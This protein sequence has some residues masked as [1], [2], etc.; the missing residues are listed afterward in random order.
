M[1]RKMDG[2]HSYVVVFVLSINWQS[3][4]QCPPYV[5]DQRWLHARRP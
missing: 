4:V 3:L 5:W 1:E 2:S